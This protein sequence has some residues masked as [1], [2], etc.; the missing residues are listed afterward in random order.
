MGQRP[1]LMI[2]LTSTYMHPTYSQITCGLKQFTYDQVYGG[3]GTSPSKFYNDCVLPMVKG[4]FQGYNATVRLTFVSEK[5]R[6]LYM[7]MDEHHY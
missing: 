4:V 5:Y 1:G 7:Q 3:S 6:T 2:E